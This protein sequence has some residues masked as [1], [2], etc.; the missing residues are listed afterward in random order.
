MLLAKV[1]ACQQSVLR[2]SPKNLVGKHNECCK[3]PMMPR[4]FCILLLF[5]CLAACGTPKPKLDSTSLVR[6]QSGS[7]DKIYSLLEY[8]AKQ[9]PSNEAGIAV[10]YVEGENTTI[11]FVGNSTFTEETL[12][13]YASITK[14]LTANI[15]MQLVNEGN[16]HLDD[17]LNEFLPEDIQDQQWE[18]VT[19]RHLATHTAGI[20]DLPP[21]L[22]TVRLANLGIDPF[23]NSDE[24]ELYQDIQE[25]KVGSIG[26][27]KYSNY[28][29][30]RF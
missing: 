22:S 21:S 29:L 5:L 16:L 1:K 7:A 9:L 30:S 15:L 25:T 4:K 17:S 20:P 2:T 27:W 11:A 28:G 18:A 14:V 23:A 26:K 10:G 6:I 3:P 13:E 24:A 12:F 8:L 19:L